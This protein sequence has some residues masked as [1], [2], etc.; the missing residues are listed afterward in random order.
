MNDSNVKLLRKQ[1]V[2]VVQGLL[3]TILV[4]ELITA[5][6][7][8]LAEQVDHRLNGIAEH[9]KA[10]LEQI[11]QRAKEVHA[12]TIRNTTNPSIKPSEKIQPPQQ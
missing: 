1:L 9:M 2:N 3:P 5:L 4:N 8:K 7:K 12:Y 6:H 10:T 11:D